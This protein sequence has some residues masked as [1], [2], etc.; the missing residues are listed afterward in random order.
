MENDRSKFPPH[1]VI[2]KE[3][4]QKS[5]VILNKVPP[6]AYGVTYIYTNFSV[7]LIPET[8]GTDRNCR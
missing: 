8:A 1:N 4:C 2:S 3:N 6:S 7:K 5:I